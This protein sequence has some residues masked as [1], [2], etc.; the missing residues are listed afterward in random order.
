MKLHGIAAATVMVLVGLVL[1]TPVASAASTAHPEG[2]RVASPDFSKRLRTSPV[3]MKASVDSSVL[4]TLRAKGSVE[5]I[6]TVRVDDLLSG[7]L[8]AAGD[9][10]LSRA[11]LARIRRAFSTAETQS[12]ARPHVSVLRQWDNLPTTFVRIESEAALD[13]LLADPRV[14]SVTANNV[15]H[16]LSGQHLRV[17]RQPEAQQAGHAG[18][19]KVVAVLDSGID[20]RHPEFGSCSAPGEGCRVLGLVEIAPNDGKLDDGGHGSNVGG[21]VAK[22]APGAKLLGYDIFR[23]DGFTND[24]LIQTALNHLIGLKNQGLPVVAANMSLGNSAAYSTADCSAASSKYAAAFTA[25]RNAG[26]IPVVSAGN[27]AKGGAGGRGV[28]MP[29]CIASALTVGA[30]HDA[31]IGTFKGGSCTDPQ[32]RVDMVT[33]FSQTGPALDMLA[34]GSNI[35]AGGWIMSGTSQAAPHVAGAVAVL[36][37]ASP[38]ATTTQIESALVST[39]PTVRDSRYPITY[40]RHRLDVF[41]AV[42]ALLGNGGGGGGVDRTPPVVTVPQ[43]SFIA[44]PITDTHVPVRLTWSASDR[45]GVT[46]YEVI[47]RE[48]GGA[49]TLQPGVTPTATAW[50][51]SLALGSTYEFAVRARDRAGNWSAYQF[52]APITPRAT[53]DTL[54]AVGDSAWNHYQWPG[55]AFGG[56]GITTSQ[57]GAW[58]NYTFTGRDVALV[59]PLHLAGGRASIYCDGALKATI[60]LYSATLRPRE[61][62]YSCAFAQAGQHTMKLIVEGT[63]GRPRFDVDAFLTLG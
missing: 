63:S 26:I 33:C 54:F 58:V 17:I 62:V 36:A 28:S 43:D 7:A 9:A 42:R 10:T 44:G 31:D 8:G 50:T 1:T 38:S 11:A 24:A 32:T 5:A 45:G 57:A 35:D 47:S 51:F 52:A 20:P 59:A 34:P 15:L 22:V 40:S 21:I 4:E 46:G 56:T 18:N 30:T 25:A 13:A 61:I 3:A 12:V 19:G 48:N 39:G 37:A 23:S 14:A 41:A 6:V 60:D 49:W 2:S 29:G 55:Y 53:D 27:G 16:S